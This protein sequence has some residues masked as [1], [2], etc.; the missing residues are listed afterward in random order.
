M[1]SKLCFHTGQARSVLQARDLY[2]W[3]E[4]SLG[5]HWNSSVRKDTTKEPDVTFS[6]W[7]TSEIYFFFK[8]KQGIQDCLCLYF[9]I[10]RLLIFLISK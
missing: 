1:N 6:Y 2:V 3:T 7:T 10:A 8:K 5:Q 9:E 4:V